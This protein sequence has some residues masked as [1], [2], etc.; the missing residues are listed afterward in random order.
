MVYLTRRASFS[1]AHRLWSNA[2]TEK[3][4]RDLYDKC[5]NPNGHGQPVWP[6][7][8]RETQAMQSLVPPNPSSETNFA[9]VHQCDFWD[10]LSG[11]TL[12]AAPDQRADND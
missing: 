12:P 2:L 1:A 6:R 3:E 10:A 9:A 11:R 7:F 4:N 5:A 8:N